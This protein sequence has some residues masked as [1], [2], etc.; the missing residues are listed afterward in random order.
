MN[1]LRLLSAA[2]SVALAIPALAAA[3]KRATAGRAPAPITIGR[4]SESPVSPA[5][6]AQKRLPT[7]VGQTLP[8]GITAAGTLKDASAS[9]AAGPRHAAPVKVLG[10]G[11]TIYG[12]PISASNWTS[13][14]YG[15]YSFKAAENPNPTRVVEFTSY[16]ANGGGCYV[17]G[18]FYYNSY[19]YT[20]EMGYTFT[21]FLT[22]DLASGQ[23]TKQTQGFINETFNLSQITNDMTYDPVSDRILVLSYIAVEEAEGLITKYYPSL[24][25]IDRHTG[26]VSPIA[27]IPQ[28]AAIACSQSGVLYGVTMG[29][30]SRLCRIDKQSGDITEIGSTGLDVNY[31]QSMTFDPVTD[32]LYW[33]AVTTAGNTGLYT[34]NLTSGAA[35]KI[36]DFPN[37][38]EFTSLYIPSPEVKDAAPAKVQEITPSFSNGS[39]SGKLIVKAPALTFSGSKLSG[40]VTLKVDVDGAEKYNSQVDAGQS[41]E[42]PLT[43]TEGTHSFAA[44]AEN[45]SG[46]G[47]RTGVAAYVGI[48]A[49]AQPG[50]ITVATDDKGRAI[51]SWTA[52]TAGRHGGYIDPAQITYNVTRMPDG[53]QV[54]TGITATSAIDPLEVDASNY[55]YTVTPYIG[56]REG[57]SAN[58]ETRLL[59]G[60]SALP[61]KWD[62][63]T[64]EQF[65]LFTTIDANND[66]DTQYQWGQWMYGYDFRSLKD[67]SD[68]RAVVY[69]YHP[70]N[71]ADD[72]VIT[73]PVKLKKGKKYRL[74]YTMWTRGDKENLE[75][76]VGTANSVAAQRVITPSKEYTHKDHKVFTQDFTAE[77]DG[78]HYAGFHITSGKKKYY[79]FVT[80]IMV[81]EVPDADAPAAVEN[82]QATPG[83]KGA[84]TA[85]VSFKAPS[86]TMAGTALSS[87]SKI[88]IYR[89]NAQEACHTFTSPKAGAS[90]TW[91]DT[92]PA[93]GF[94]TYRVVAFSGESAGQKAETT[95]FVG[96]DTPLPPADIAVSDASGKPVITWTA[97]TEGVNGGYIDPA[98][99]TYIIYRDGDSADFLHNAFKGTQYTDTGLDPKKMQY[100]VRYAVFAV[101]STGRS[102]FAVTEPIVYGDP[103]AAPYSDSF[104]DSYS[105]TN[106]WV[107]YKIKGNT[108][109]WTLAS[110]SDTP[111]CSNADSDGGMLSFQSGL[112]RIGDESR[113]VSPKISLEGLS[114]PLLTFYFYHNYSEEH[115]YY[116]NQLQ[117]RLIP[118]VQLSDGTYEA[119]IDSAIYVDDLGKGW[120]K[121][122]LP[123]DKYKAQPYVR[124]AFRGISDGQQN[125]NVDLVRITNDI[126]KDIQLYTLSGPA[127]AKVGKKA[128]Y[129]ATFYNR[130][131]L[132][133]TGFKIQLLQDGRKIDEYAPKT[134][135]SG[136]YASFDFPVEFSL[137]QLDKS[138]KFQAKVDWE[139]DEIEADNLSNTV[140]TRVTEPDLPEVYA[141]R[142]SVND[143]DVTLEWGA[144]EARHY[145][146]GF[147]DYTPFSINNIEDYTLVDNDKSLSYC[148]QAIHFDH[149]GDPQ[150]F[151]V[152]NPVMLGIN[153]VDDPLFGY[154]AFD[155]R[156]GQQVLCAWGAAEKAND[157][158]FISPE[159]FGSQKVT[160]YAKSGDYMQGK[161]TFEILYST[162]DTN[163]ASFRTVGDAVTTGKEWIKYEI[164]LPANARYFAIHCT[165]ADGFCLMIDDLTYVAKAAESLVPL[166]GYAIYRDG[167]KV[168][169][170]GVDVTTFT[171]RSLPDGTYT[172]DIRALYG[173]RTAPASD[174]AV[175]IV[176][177]GAVDEIAVD[178]ADAEYFT[179]SGLRAQRPL[180][181]GVYIE[182]RQGKAHKVFVK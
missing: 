114:R 159:V 137:D 44:T 41:V 51:I 149:A 105:Q 118:E 156:G 103:Y 138:L 100:F 81:D 84:M 72:W 6:S 77:A 80:D 176:G 78:N 18:K 152:F 150:A 102:E 60:G 50:N 73:P 10:D 5:A 112:G 7:P 87:L 108:Q 16:E 154:D 155:P 37:N 175:A 63:S 66:A 68:K 110:S 55:Y 115:E 104:A 4:P 179:L 20:E 109:L 136:E 24:S 119:L 43:L 144:P 96:V 174:K 29:K 12:F 57:L 170:T 39:L 85:T 91:T 69:G 106:P 113:I 98:A 67:D 70:E 83:A 166:T 46:A 19:V 14:Q 99:L 8:R 30:D 117:D 153:I 164:D 161:D 34:L 178:A 140:T 182:L 129:T 76:T 49:P 25:E 160:F 126:Q 148:F 142:H 92:D 11:T 22:Y 139:E 181:P 133:A 47:P 42:I 65:A 177:T 93:P 48:D 88:D 26:M 172:Y 125:I 75:V 33:A 101:S 21:T 143:H 180:Q 53:A 13:P 173:T 28:M 94:N 89:G 134:L 52:P 121:Y 90:L 158:W 38:E 120:L 56:Q 145:N 135:P 79:L 40:K 71:A 122:A 165:S 9:F 97:P 127:K 45:A 27:R 124:I 169:E 151:M 107:T 62:L 1:K 157:D 23:L 36:C 31:T 146:E 2:L 74:T 59:G 123:L 61:V 163:T 162:S 86:K 17:D 111:A 15:I 128:V 132:P 141:L 82:L 54:A 95:I 131:S 32:L 171:D 3:P 168:G 130:G 167:V 147:E 35:S 64:P 116:E 58:S